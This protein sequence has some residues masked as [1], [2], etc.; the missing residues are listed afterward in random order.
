MIDFIKIRIFNLD[1]SGIRNPD[2][3]EWLQ[4]TNE[5][6]GEIKEYT[7]M[8]HGLT[9]QI[10]DNKHLNISGSIHK[11]RNTITGLGDQNYNDF[12]FS[13][14]I[15]VVNAFC[16]TFDLVPDQCILE[17]FE[18]GVNITPPIR[19]NEILRSVI[20]HKG[21]PFNRKQLQLFT[22]TMN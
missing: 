14:L 3:L 21:K 15:Q 18:F 6:T 1:I 11:H 20:N 9:F 7:A 5:R 8:F 16:K 13:N 2:R 17:N 22:I 12:N 10:I 4:R 19:V